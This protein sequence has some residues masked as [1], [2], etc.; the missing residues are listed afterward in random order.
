MRQTHSFDTER[1]LMSLSS[2]AP[3]VAVNSAASKKTATKT[4][5]PNVILQNKTARY[6]QLADA[7][8]EVK[9]KEEASN[10]NAASASSESANTGVSVAEEK[11]T[12]HTVDWEAAISD[13]GK[14]VRLS[15]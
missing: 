4:K 7:L 15:S 13:H 14:A 10:S 8:D 3:L 11:P 2:L 5:S 12:E 9:S 1:M 6:R